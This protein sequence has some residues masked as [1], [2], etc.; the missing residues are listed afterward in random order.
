MHQ[1]TCNGVL[2]GIRICRKGFPS[3]TY[4]PDFKQRYS[5]LSPVSAKIADP[6]KSSGGILKDIALSEELYKLGHTKVF[7]K[8]GV[9]GQ[10]EERRD[11]ALAKILSMLQAQIRAYIL[12]REFKKMLSQ[13]LAQNVLQR[14][15]KAYLVLRNWTWWKLL[16]KIKPLLK[17]SQK[18]VNI[19]FLCNLKKK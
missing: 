16:S 5:I 12:Q 13:R 18:E 4:Y 10:L 15:I 2:E 1:L 19:T 7:F 3:R 6:I 17:N 14:N 11:N 9:V 8:A